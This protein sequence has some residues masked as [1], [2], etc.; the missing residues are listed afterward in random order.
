M[1]ESR[2]GVF[3]KM[4]NCSFK[5]IHL[6][7]KRE[8]LF[9]VSWRVNIQGMTCFSPKQMDSRGEEVKVEVRQSSTPARCCSSECKLQ[10]RVAASQ[11]EDANFTS[12]RCDVA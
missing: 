4:L 5:H 12:D 2:L 7:F 6:Y 9:F 8:Y 11:R 10:G 1:C 3:L